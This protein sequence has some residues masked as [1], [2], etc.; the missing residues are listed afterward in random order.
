MGG[1]N[2]PKEI[3]AGFTYEW[4]E[5]FSQYPAST[6][7]L[8]ATFILNTY[9]NT[10]ITVTAV[11]SGDSFTL[12]IPAATSANFTAGNYKLYLFVTLGAAKYLVGNQDVVIKANPLTATGDTRS[13]IQKVLDAIEAVLENRATQEYQSMN[14]NGYSITQMSPQELL[15]LKDYYEGKLKTEQNK[16][17]MAQGKPSKRTILV[18]L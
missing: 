18:Q 17:A 11:A 7:G 15:K 13:H 10:R 1:M 16:E 6:Y 9:G 12:T 14:I 5:S 2:A 4:Q 3:I 8:T